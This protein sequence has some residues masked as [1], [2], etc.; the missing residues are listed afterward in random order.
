M[1][2]G[3]CTFYVSNGTMVHTM[4]NENSDPYLTATPIFEPD[5]SDPNIPKAEPDANDFDNILV[6]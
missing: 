6:D 5:N 3:T 1:N 2:T 4:G